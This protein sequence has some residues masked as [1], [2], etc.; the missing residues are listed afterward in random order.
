MNPTMEAPMR[1]VLQGMGAIPHNEGTAFRVW[2]PNAQGVSVVGDFNDWRED[3]DPMASEGNGHWYADLGN[4]RVGSE[5]RFFLVNGD[6]RLSRIDP[7]AREVTNSVG[8]AVVFDPRFDWQDDAFEMPPLNKLV[9]YELHV[10]SFAPREKGHPGNFASVVDRFSHLK[11]LGVNVL[12]IM[13]AAEFSGDYSWGYNPANIFAVE[14]AYGGPKAFKEFVKQAHRNGFAVIM[15]VVYNHF[16]PSD[17]SLWQFDGWSEYGMGGIYFYNDWRA[18]TPW[19]S[20]RPD[21]GRGEVRQ[22]IRDNAMMWLEDYHLDGLRFDMT[23]FMRSVRGNGD[24]GSNLPDG[25][26]LAQWI[27]SEVRAKFPEKITIAE[28]LQNDEALTSPA[29]LGGA[30]F[31]SQ[32]D[33]QFVHPVRTALILADDA[34][35]SISSIA[36]AVSAGYNGDAFRRVVYTESHDEVANGKA[37]VPTEISPQDSGSIFAQKRSA[38]GAVLVFTSPGVPM[39]FQGQ[40]FLQDQWFRDDV[41]LDWHLRD[42]YRGIVRLY[43]DLVHLRLNRRETTRG[44]SGQNVQ[45]FHVDEIGDVLAYHRWDR[46]GPN[47]DTIVALN[48][49]NE[50]RSDYRIGLPAAGLWRRRLNTDDQKY[51]ADLTDVGGDDVE[52]EAVPCS[53]FEHSARVQL[54]A[55]GAVILSQSIRKAE[56]T[57]P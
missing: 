42:E 22:F 8:N 47:D 17:L 33:A 50:Q 34:N 32:W 21:Y 20:T 55:Y 35:R 25:W 7:Y 44:L 30:G 5:Y 54:G 29:E 49:S 39:I 27:N 19:G 11:E 41:P 6:Q 1:P 14:S 48:F 4:A 53:G 2:A 43:R 37:R 38:L 40:E 31:H 46:G 3:A 15:D 9:V 10:G 57:S 18:E 23:L 52:A 12:E 13:P 56:E 28:D 45:V 51:G 24:P 36:Q 26:A 16:G